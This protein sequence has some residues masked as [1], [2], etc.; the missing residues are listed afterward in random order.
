[1]PCP[2]RAPNLHWLKEGH[3][4]AVI[5]SLGAGQPKASLLSVKAPAFAGDKAGSESLI[6]IAAIL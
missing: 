4:N 3:A 6:T 2:S 5:P 1:L